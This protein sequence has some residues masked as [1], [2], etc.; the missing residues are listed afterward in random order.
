VLL[1]ITSAILSRTVGEPLTSDPELHLGALEL[2]SR[3]SNPGLD[4][5]HVGEDSGE[6]TKNGVV[7]KTL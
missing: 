5:F 3:D 4:V 6:P 2:G 7:V 1:Q